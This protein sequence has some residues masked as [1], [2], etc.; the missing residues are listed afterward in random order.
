MDRIYLVTGGTGFL[1]SSLISALL[2][3]GDQVVAISR[4]NRAL[5]PRCTVIRGELTEL[6]NLRAL[7]NL[8]YYACFHFAGAS[9][10]PLSWDNPTI[11]FEKGL[12]ST[13]ALIHFLGQHHPACKVLVS[14]SAAVYGNPRDYPVNE[15]ADIVPISPYGIH[16]AAIELLCEHYSRLL[17]LRVTVMR[18]FS[19]YGVGLRKQL[20]WDTA[21]KLSRATLDGKSKISMLGTGLES[22]DFIHVTDVSRAAIC[23]AEAALPGHFNLV[24]VAS[25]EEVQVRQIVELLCQF[26]GH[27]INPIFSGENRAGDPQ[28]WVADLTQLSMLGFSPQ[29]TLTVGVQQYANWAKA[30]FCQH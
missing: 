7:P 26:W 23:L 2:D 24:N 28:R 6:F 12:P 30:I 18:I 8:D 22:R 17:G 4:N 27:G 16:K 29:V 13:L 20:L 14:S 9:S 10:V 11:D 5:D 15:G 1:G 19:A 21:L 3:R 25:G